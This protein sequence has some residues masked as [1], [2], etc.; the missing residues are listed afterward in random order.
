MEIPPLVDTA[1]VDFWK[2]GKTTK[3]NWDFFSEILILKLKS[4]GGSF[5]L[6]LWGGY[7]KAYYL[8]ILVGLSVHFE[9]NPAIFLLQIIFKKSYINQIG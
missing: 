4:A 5:P 6:I 7:E 3:I 9:R 8:V 2:K 1:S